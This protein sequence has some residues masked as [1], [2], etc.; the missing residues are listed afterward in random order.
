[1]ADNVN[2]IEF[3]DEVKNSSI[4]PDNFE[5]VY[6]EF[7][8][9]QMAALDTLKEI[10][11]VCE[12]N[13]VPYQLEYGSLLGFVR[14]DGQIPWDYDVDIIVPYEQKENLIAALKKDLNAG[15]YLYCPEVDKKCRH[16]IMRI[17]PVEYTTAALHVDVF[18]FIGT[19]EDP[20]ERAKFARRI[21]QLSEIRFNKL[22]KINEVA[23]G[24]PVKA[25]KMFIQLKLPTLFVNISAIQQEYEALCST[26]SSSESTYCISADFFATWKEV[27][28]VLLWETKLAQCKYGTMRIPVHYEKLLELFYGDYKSVPPLK[29][30]INEVL[31]HHRAITKLQKHK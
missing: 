3:L 18:F 30:R 10:H 1:M 11:R 20:E 2:D 27:P 16:M 22:V 12:K 5:K 14:D 23:L 7:Q 19:P 9:F 8:K 25:L 21:K 28:S 17:A 24:N 26:Y 31:V 13:N 4:C 29:N 6:A 15:Y